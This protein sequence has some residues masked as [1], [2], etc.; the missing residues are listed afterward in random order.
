MTGAESFRSPQGSSAGRSPRDDI[1][2]SSFP[3]DGVLFL[4]PTLPQSLPIK[5]QP[6]SPS[7]NPK[8]SDSFAFSGLQ[9]RDSE[10]VESGRSNL[11]FPRNGFVSSQPLAESQGQFG[12][13]FS[14]RIGSFGEGPKRVQNPVIIENFNPPS[15]NLWANFRKT[16]H[17][18]RSENL[19]KKHFS[20]KNG[21]IPEGIEPSFA[22]VPP[23]DPPIGRNTRPISENLFDISGQ[24]SIPSAAFSTQPKPQKISHTPVMESPQEAFKADNSRRNG[25]FEGRTL[26]DRADTNYYEDDYYYLEDDVNNAGVTAVPPADDNDYVYDYFQ[27]Y[28]DFKSQLEK[29]QSTVIEKPPSLMLQADDDRIGTEGKSQP[30]AQ[31]DKLNSEKGMLLPATVDTKIQEPEITTEN[32]DGVSHSDKVGDKA[33]KNLNESEQETDS[34]GD[35]DYFPETDS[36]DLEN[37]TEMSERERDIHRTAEILQEKLKNPP[38]YGRGSFRHRINL[39]VE[40]R[41]EARR[42]RVRNRTTPPS[43]A[44]STT[45]NVPKPPGIDDLPGFIKEK[46]HVRRNITNK[47][48]KLDFYTRLRNRIFTPSDTRTS[49]TTEVSSEGN[50]TPIAITQENGINTEFNEK[51]GKVSIDEDLENKNIDI[52]V[53]ENS[54]NHTADRTTERFSET[55]TTLIPDEIITTDPS[56][57]DY[58]STILDGIEST[59]ANTLSTTD[60]YYSTTNYDYSEDD[61]YNVQGRSFLNELLDENVKA[62]SITGPSVEIITGKSVVS[63]TNQGVTK[64]TSNTGTSKAMDPVTR[65]TTSPTTFMLSNPRTPVTKEVSITEETIPQTTGQ[66]I[67]PTT[68]LVTESSDVAADMDLT[69]VEMLDRSLSESETTVSTTFLPQEIE[70]IEELYHSTSSQPEVRIQD[71][72]LELASDV[73]E[74]STPKHSAAADVIE[75]ILNEAP[76]IKLTTD[77]PDILDDIVQEMKNT[78][79]LMKNLDGKTSFTKIERGKK[80]SPAVKTTITLFTGGFANQSAKSEKE[81]PTSERIYE[82]EPFTTVPTDGDSDN[83]IR[84]STSYPLIS[85]SVVDEENIPAK[86]PEQTEMPM[87]ELVTDPFS[88]RFQ[89]RSNKGEIA[90]PELATDSSFAQSAFNVATRPP[91]QMTTQSSLTRLQQLLHQFD[92][93][94][95]PELSA[96]TKFLGLGIESTA[97]PPHKKKNSLLKEQER[98]WNER[99]NSHFQNLGNTNGGLFGNTFRSPRLEEFQ[100]SGFQSSTSQQALTSNDISLINTRRQTLFSPD[101]DDLSLAASEGSSSANTELMESTTILNPTVTVPDTPPTSINDDLSPDMTTKSLP[102]TGTETPTTPSPTFSEF[103]T[104]TSITT[105]I[106]TEIPVTTA[107]TDDT[108]S[109]SSSDLT[110]D[111]V[112]L[113]EASNITSSDVDKLISISTN[114]T[115]VDEILEKFAKVE[116]VTTG[117]LTAKVNDTNEATNRTL[118]LK[119]FLLMRQ[120]SSSGDLKGRSDTSMENGLSSDAV[121][122]RLRLLRIFKAKKER[123]TG[124]SGIRKHFMKVKGATKVYQRTDEVDLEDI[125]VRV[126]TPVKLRDILSKRHEQERIRQERERDRQREAERK[127]KLESTTITPPPSLR[128]QLLKLRERN[129]KEKMSKTP[130]FDN[131]VKVNGFRIIKD[132]EQEDEQVTETDTPPSTTPSFVVTDTTPDEGEFFAFLPTI[133]PPSQTSSHEIFHQDTT[134]NSNSESREQSPDFVSDAGRNRRPLPPQNVMSQQSKMAAFGNLQD[135]LKRQTPRNESSSLA[136]RLKNKMNSSFLPTLPPQ[137]TALPKPFVETNNFDHRFHDHKSRNLPS[138]RHKFVPTTIPDDFTKSIGVDFHVTENPDLDLYYDYYDYTT[139]DYSG[140]LD[141]TTSTPA[142]FSDFKNTR[143][144]FL[145]P[146]EDDER[147]TVLEKIVEDQFESPFVQLRD[148][149]DFGRKEENTVGPEEETVIVTDALKDEIHAFLAEVGDLSDA[150]ITTSSDFLTEDIKPTTRKIEKDERLFVPPTTEPIIWHHE[151]VTERNLLETTTVDDVINWDDLETP[152]TEQKLISHGAFSQSHDPRGNIKHVIQPPSHLETVSPR[153]VS[154]PSAILRGTLTS[155]PVTRPSRVTVVRTIIPNIVPGSDRN[156]G[157]ISQNQNKRPV[158]NKQPEQLPPVPSFTVNF[159]KTPP[160]SHSPSSFVKQSSFPFTPQ[161]PHRDDGFR[162]GKPLEQ[163][164]F[165]H[166]QPTSHHS[167]G[168]ARR[169]H[170]HFENHFNIHHSPSFSFNNQQ[171]S[172]SSQQNNFFNN[173]QEPIASPQVR[174]SPFLLQKFVPKSRNE[175][176]S[177]V[178]EIKLSPFRKFVQNSP[179]TFS[180]TEIQHNGHHRLTDT[181]TASSNAFSLVTTPSTPRP[182]SVVNLPQRGFQITPI[183]HLMTTERFTHNEAIPRS[184]N[185]GSQKSEISNENSAISGSNIHIRQHGHPNISPSSKS[186]A[187]VTLKPLISLSRNTKPKVQITAVPNQRFREIEDKVKK[188]ASG[189]RPEETLSQK[190]N[191]QGSSRVVQLKNVLPEPE[192][193]AQLPPLKFDLNFGNVNFPHIR[194][195]SNQ[196]EFSA[197]PKPSSVLLPNKFNRHDSFDRKIDSVSLSKPNSKFSASLHPHVL[198]PSSNASPSPTSIQHPISGSGSPLNEPVP[199][200]P[201]EGFQEE[202][203]LIRQSPA[204]FIPQNKVPLNPWARMSI[205]T[206]RPGILLPLANNGSVSYL[207]ELH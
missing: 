126:N 176:A 24:G 194:E 72:E 141:S 44:I 133:P 185:S 119:Q 165:N 78:T 2:I 53:T 50:E 25:K 193:I 190:T 68:S 69:T 7:Q 175:A 143:S 106:T 71:G 87:P 107:F 174:D 54:A 121:R 81:N 205:S 60:N 129:K 112:M 178:S 100:D 56:F 111:D 186:N 207:N 166:R 65:V 104:S 51:G 105:E 103:D 90:S 48:G 151:T 144:K 181:K 63:S 8:P 124:T 183:P 123:Q 31:L 167:I 147:N 75:N 96:M 200:K 36:Q 137:T 201:F 168:T 130:N 49:T 38:K 82:T 187:Q 184:H 99:F 66:D 93:N 169:S 45:N 149:A 134:Q 182:R 146:D 157:T 160:Q 70:P 197:T 16:S 116:E 177:A 67:E 34:S 13:Q 27:Y 21:N 88:K 198:A 192:P 77:V 29:E 158:F 84:K 59:T 26:I 171:S 195:N 17:I 57:S 179:N 140:I 62:I 164:N 35:D 74:T 162:N 148:N 10:V 172:R 4:P 155:A 18:N 125:G 33:E 47:A 191:F 89:S 110:D 101:L 136:S 23:D 159:D 40:K 14:S 9:G 120:D 85:A 142:S 202:G 115:G 3:A 73:P 30:A 22:L 206:P 128:E 114:S 135:L 203:P 92:P 91:I 108:S 199:L 41:Q 95:R 153:R 98:K 204:Q 15:R 139:D 19:D 61:D 55:Q 94:A 173:Q 127:A 122:E 131:I 6:L 39:L 154:P 132:E 180:D 83:L 11:K 43:V 32:T 161:Q 86:I 42:S 196:N 117:R 46:V 5:P 97:F 20:R 1:S 138:R 102:V 76:V 58:Y 28:D 79:M 12:S 156:F 189:S 64:I 113:L 118:A 163:T 170:S 109:N 145:E 80:N 150:E 52:S 188:V 37:T 152:P